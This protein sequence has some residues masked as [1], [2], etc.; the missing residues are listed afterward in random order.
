MWMKPT[1]LWPVLWALWK[2]TWFQTSKRDIWL[3]NYTHH[4]FCTN[5]AIGRCNL[6]LVANVGSHRCGPAIFFF[7]WGRSGVFFKQ[8]HFCFFRF[9]QFGQV[10]SSTSHCW[11]RLVI[12][13]AWFFQELRV[14][15]L[16]EVLKGGATRFLQASQDTSHISLSCNLP[17]WWE[18]MF[19][20]FSWWVILQKSAGKNM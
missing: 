5:A 4:I 18:K 13:R 6:H 8:H 3:F 16:R 10:S 7:L 11:S 12:S 19:P 14:V 15:K 2:M 17:F 1:C 20:K 9:A